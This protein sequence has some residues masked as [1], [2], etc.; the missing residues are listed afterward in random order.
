MYK[1]I[2]IGEKRR[3]SFDFFF[4]KINF[5]RMINNRYFAYKCLQ[6]SRRN[7][8][9]I[10]FSFFCPYCLY[11]LKATKLIPFKTPVSGNKKVSKIKTKHIYLYM[12]LIYTFF[13]NCVCVFFFSTC[14]LIFISR[15]P[16]YYLCK[17]SQNV[18]MYLICCSNDFSFFKPATHRPFNIIYIIILI[19]WK[20]IHNK[21]G[22]MITNTLLYLKFRW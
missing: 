13:F 7:K 16:F 9:H 20:Q 1:H 17:A 5:I 2:H 14:N 21:Y 12:Y 10:K 11:S 19:W 4:S 15:E 6:N 3:N 18:V 8:N 22:N